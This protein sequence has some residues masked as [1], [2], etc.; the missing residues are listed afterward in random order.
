MTRGGTDPVSE[1][2][3]RRSDVPELQREIR[4][5]TGLHLDLR[6]TCE[7]RAIIEGLVS[8]DALARLW[9]DR[10]RVDR[11]VRLAEGLADILQELPWLEH[12]KRLREA[13][14]AFRD[15]TERLKADLWPRGCRRGRP[16]KYWVLVLA[17]SVAD[18][19]QKHGR[20]G[21]GVWY[22]KARTEWRG[23][24]FMLARLIADRVKPMLGPVS[25]ETLGERLQQ[26]ARRANRVKSGSK[27]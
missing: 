2:P 3:E 11:A 7:I 10:Q 15:K 21:S 1:L 20:G 18:F 16:P 22:D 8:I 12:P 25:D 17:W 24:A 23:R 9:K 4:E 27:R 6:S 19:W 14:R 13:L 5:A 26:A